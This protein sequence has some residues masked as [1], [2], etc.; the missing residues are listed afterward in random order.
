MR[1]NATTISTSD[2]IIEAFFFF[3]KTAIESDIHPITLAPNAIHKSETF[4]I[5]VASLILRL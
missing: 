3:A 4:V 1:T 5:T 2:K